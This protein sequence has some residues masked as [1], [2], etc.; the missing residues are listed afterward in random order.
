MEGKVFL[1]Q[2]ILLHHGMRKY[3]W[4]KKRFKNM[5]GAESEINWDADR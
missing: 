2:K 3:L 4:A 5:A 1:R